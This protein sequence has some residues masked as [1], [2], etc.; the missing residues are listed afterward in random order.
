MLN[1]VE[2]ISVDG[3][4]VTLSGQDMLTREQLFVESYEVLIH[5]L[6]AYFC[7]EVWMAAEYAEDTR[8]AAEADFEQYRQHQTFLVGRVHSSADALPLLIVQVGCQLVWNS[9]EVSTMEVHLHQHNREFNV[10][11]QHRPIKNPFAQL[12]GF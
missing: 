7:L 6:L 11:L 12:T 2:E 8:K 3:N 9:M 4:K 1:R 5:T 10:I